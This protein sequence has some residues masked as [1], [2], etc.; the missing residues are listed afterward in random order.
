MLDDNPSFNIEYIFMYSK[1][2]NE[3]YTHYILLNSVTTSI[4]FYFFIII[5]KPLGF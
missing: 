5:D 2:S 4:K 1:Y 3:K